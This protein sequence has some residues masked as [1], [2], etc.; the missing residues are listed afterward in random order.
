MS[1]AVSDIHARQK[2]F[3]FREYVNFGVFRIKS[4][5]SEQLSVLLSSLAGGI[6]MEK[7]FIAECHRETLLI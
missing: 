7:S 6:G 3:K 2:R 5:T 4:Q 1:I